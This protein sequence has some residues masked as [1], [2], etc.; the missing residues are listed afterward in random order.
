ML[1]NTVFTVGQAGMIMNYIQDYIFKNKNVTFKLISIITFIL[2]FGFYLIKT[3]SI[4]G[5]RNIGLGLGNMLVCLLYI[6]FIINES[7]ST[8]ADL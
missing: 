7:I 3:I 8:V 1:M 5:E 4:F 6:L 2:L